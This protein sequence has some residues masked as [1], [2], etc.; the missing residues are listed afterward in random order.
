M[1]PQ[2][3]LV[4]LAACSSSARQSLAPSN[5]GGQVSLDSGGVPDA[6]ILDYGGP[7]RVVLDGSAFD[8]AAP[9]LDSRAFDLAS[10]DSVPTSERPTV[11]VKTTDTGKDASAG[12]DAGV[13]IG[14]ALDT[15]QALDSGPCGARQV[16]V[17]GTC[18]NCGGTGQLCCKDA[19]SC[20][21]QSICLNNSQCFRCGDLGGMCCD[22]NQCAEGTC[23]AGVCANG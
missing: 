10:L 4:L 6:V 17:N 5:D 18:Q 7:D 14:A 16:L 8:G 19:P 9:S 21:A 12:V 3:L 15:L 20:G 2:A 23:K 22:G 11:E 13:D 1:K